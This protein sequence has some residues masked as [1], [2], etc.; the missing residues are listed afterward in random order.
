MRLRRYNRP[1]DTGVLKE[2][3]KTSSYGY[4]K[5]INCLRL[6]FS[7]YKS[8]IIGLFVTNTI[9]FTTLARADCGL[10]GKNYPEGT[11]YSSFICTN[12]EW[13]KQTDSCKED[14]GHH[15]CALGIVLN[16][17]CEKES[18][19]SETVCTLSEFNLSISIDDSELSADNVNKA[20][21][22]Q[23]VKNAGCDTKYSCMFVSDIQGLC[24]GGYEPN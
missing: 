13:V 1:E 21:A 22:E 6:P 20:L 11:T 18:K 14:P 12:N 10:D 24:Y 5:Q 8:L 2:I 19:S 15:I 7:F 17:D 9:L 23:C 3:K 4:M 16:A